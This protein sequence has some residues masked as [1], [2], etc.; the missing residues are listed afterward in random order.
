MPTLRPEVKAKWTEALRSGTYTQ[1][2]GQLRDKANN[3][4]CLGVLCEVAVQEGVIPPARIFEGWTDYGFGNGPANDTRTGVLPPS[5][6][7][8]AFEDYKPVTEDRVSNFEDPILGD[9]HASNW[10]DD[11]DATFVKIADLVEAYL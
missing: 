6:Q 4:C 8:W 11:Y 7:E 10:N 5:V 1:G 9:H 3:Y 2:V